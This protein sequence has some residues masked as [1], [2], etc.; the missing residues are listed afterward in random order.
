MTSNGRKIDVKTVEKYLSAF[1]GAYILYQAKRYDVKGKQHLKTLEK[2][3]APDIG[4]RYTLLGRKNADTGYILENVVYLE[5][6]RRGFE[7]YVGKVG[8]AEV[9]FVAVTPKGTTYYQVS[10]SVREQSV[11]ERELASLRSINDHYPKILLTL[12]EDPEG[13]YNGIIKLNALDWLVNN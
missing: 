10:T 13:D 11:L 12:D 2:Y 9:D 8:P 6:I 5:L 1:T 4:L 7:V 3:Y